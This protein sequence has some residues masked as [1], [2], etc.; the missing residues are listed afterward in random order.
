MTV[1]LKKSDVHSA[2]WAGADELRGGMDASQY[3]DYVLTLLL[4]KYV[5]QGQGRPE[6]PHR[7]ARERFVRQSRL[8]PRAERHRRQGQQGHAQACGR[9]RL[10][11]APLAEEAW[12]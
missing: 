2:L 9:Q 3:K 4:V 7:G 1:V 11:G 12:T 5:G 10:N 8:I 6:Q